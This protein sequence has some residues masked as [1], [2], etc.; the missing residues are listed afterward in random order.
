MRDSEL[1]HEYISINTAFGRVGRR[2]D[3]GH[4]VAVLGNGHATDHRAEDRSGKRRIPVVPPAV[5]TAR[6]SRTAWREHDDTVITENDST[7]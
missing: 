5:P 1:L 7:T 2:D 3:I 6:V 4:V